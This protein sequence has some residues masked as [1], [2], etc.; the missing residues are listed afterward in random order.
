MA[1][2]PP[3]EEGDDAGDDEDG[4]KDRVQLSANPAPRRREHLGR[5]AAMMTCRPSRSPRRPI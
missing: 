5:P 4:A 3:A 2:V 1:K